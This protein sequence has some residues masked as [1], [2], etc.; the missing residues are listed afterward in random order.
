MLDTITSSANPTAASHAAN[1]SRMMGNMHDSEKW[2]LRIIRVLRI[3]MDNIIPS[4]H[5]SD[6]IRWDR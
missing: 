1:T 5:K 3:N 6:D 4:R 2:E